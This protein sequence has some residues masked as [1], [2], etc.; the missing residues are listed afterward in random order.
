MP[1]PARKAALPI[2]DLPAVHCAGHA[3]AGRGCRSWSV[4]ER[5]AA[6]GRG[7]DDRRPERMLARFLQAR[8]EA[9]QLVFREAACR[10]DR[11][12][13]GLAFRQRA[14]LVDD[15]GIDPLHPFEG[16]GVLDEHAG[17]STATDADH[18]RHGRGETEGAGA[19]DDEDADRGY[20][21]EGEARLR[22]EHR[23]GKEGDRGDDDDQRHEPARHQ[24][25]Q[26]LDRGAAPLCLGHHLDDPREQR[27]AAD[28]LG[29]A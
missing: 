20:Q 16:F 19:G 9:E 6:F 17:L 1:S 10:L 3:F 24:I 27:V 23:P 5:H 14:G 11:R 4:G 12:D 18:D 15:Q 29:L 7:G 28:L 2:S 25:G 22:P 21:P 26:A 8:S 13:G